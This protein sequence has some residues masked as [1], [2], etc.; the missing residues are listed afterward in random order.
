MCFSG[1]RGNYETLRPPPP[2]KRRK[3]PAW[4]FLLH[5][6]PRNPD[7][8]HAPDPHPHTCQALQA[9]PTKLP[10][11]NLPVMPIAMRP[12]ASQ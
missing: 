5:Q 3:E 4:N 6:F 7:V 10:A 8:C 12:P 9:F 2:S 1:S 11:P